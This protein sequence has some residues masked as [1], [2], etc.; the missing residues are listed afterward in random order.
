MET[1]NHE[2]PVICALD[3]GWYLVVEG[4]SPEKNQ[5]FP[6][7]TL[8]NY[9]LTTAL[10]DS[11]IEPAARYTLAQVA[12]ILG[13]DLDHVRYLVTRRK[14]PVLKVGAQSWGTVRHDDLSAFLEA[15]NHCPLLQKE[16]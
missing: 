1:R 9:L 2:Y 6:G 10:R 4:T 7:R 5:P 11:G 13:C 3:G 15:V 14:L 16:G 12:A 8:M